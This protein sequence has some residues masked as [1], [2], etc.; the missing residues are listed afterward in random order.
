MI[1]QQA[2]C[3]N[4]YLCVTNTYVCSMIKCI[5][6]E[7]VEGG[8]KKEGRRKEGRERGKKKRTIEDTV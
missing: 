6:R 1:Q 7:R 4:A 3:S 8:R 5:N 2:A